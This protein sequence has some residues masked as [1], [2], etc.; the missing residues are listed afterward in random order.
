MAWKKKK[1]GRKRK[2]VKATIAKIQ[3]DVKLIKG[4]IEIKRHE[5]YDNLNLVETSDANMICCSAVAEGDS[6]DNRTGLKITP[7]MIRV[8]VRVYNPDTT[9]PA[10]A[11]I[12][13]FKDFDDKTVSGSPT[14]ATLLQYLSQAF[15]KINSPSKWVT[16]QRFQILYDKVFCMGRAGCDTAMRH[17]QFT[18][19]L[20]GNIYFNGSANTTNTY[21]H[22]WLLMITD[23]A[24]GHGMQCDYYTRM[25]YYDA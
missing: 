18:K 8:A 25:T 24:D 23:A 13:L 7:R 1:A 6:E 19:K 17:I 5:V 9:Y 22:I 10:R 20:T 11:R 15:S 21:N 14:A 16:K 3:K 4:E 2:P 12:I